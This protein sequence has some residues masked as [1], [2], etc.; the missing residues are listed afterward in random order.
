MTDWRHFTDE[1]EVI[2]LIPDTMTY[3]LK[4]GGK[5]TVPLKENGRIITKNLPVEVP[6]SYCKN[7]EYDGGSEALQCF[8]AGR[9]IDGHHFKPPVLGCY[10]LM[11][12]TNNP[13]PVDFSQCTTI[14]QFHV[15]YF[16]EMRMDALE[17]VLD[18]HSQDKVF[19]MEDEDTWTDLDKAAIS[20]IDMLISR[21]VKLERPETWYSIIEMFNESGNGFEMLPGGG[22]S[23]YWY[24]AETLGA[25]VANIGAD[26]NKTFDDIVWNTPLQLIGFAYVAKARLNGAKGVKRPKDTQDVRRHM[27][28]AYLRELHGEL[29]PWQIADPDGHH[30]TDLQKKSREC[31]KRFESMKTKAKKVS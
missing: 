26:L 31:V 11:E 14:Q 2:D 10:S 9:I 6:L 5:V 21:G 12:I 23:K 16:L 20:Y 18:W 15:L 17:L 19:D 4:K 8:G 29:H 24:C 27:I 13:F 28:L 25:V 1:S 3:D 7:K 30:L 22:S